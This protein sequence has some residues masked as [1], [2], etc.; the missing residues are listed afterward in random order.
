MKSTVAQSGGMGLEL[1]IATFGLLQRLCSMYQF[2]PS[3]G[4]F[5]LPA[6]AQGPS[7]A[8]WPGGIL[9]LSANGT[10]ADTAIVWASHT[11]TGGGNWQ[12][13]PG[14]LRAYNAQ[15]VSQELWNSSQV[16]GR[17]AVGNY[18]KFVPPTVANGKVYLA[19]FSGKLKV[20]GLLP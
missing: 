6:V 15:N 5:V 10:N 14:I 18:A 4:N 9:A 12:I 3:S 19:T 20:Y 7:G 8:Y 2:S 1:P 13:L 17:D 11:L 16:S